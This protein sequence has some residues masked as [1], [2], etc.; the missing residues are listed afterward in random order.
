MKKKTGKKK[1]GTVGKAAPVDASPIEQVDMAVA[2]AVD[3]DPDGATATGLHAVGNA[4]DQPPLVALNLLVLGAGI[5]TGNRNM[6]RTGARMLAAHGLAT[7]I[8]TV[9]KNRID[10][11]RPHRAAEHGEYELKPGTSR[12]SQLQSMPSGHSAGVVA[13]ARAVSRDNPQ[14]AIPATFGALAVAGAQLPTRAH[15]L[16]DVAVGALIGVVAE[17]ATSSLL[18]IAERAAR[19]RSGE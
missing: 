13:V 5:V 1:T 9:I 6:T 8:K 15:Y 12:K 17:V 14:L 2:D 4:G 3:V 10:R 19:D 11:T 7:V 16:S 18:D